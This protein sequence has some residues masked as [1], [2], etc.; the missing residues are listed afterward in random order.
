VLNELLR[1]TLDRALQ[2]AEQLSGTP[3]NE[4]LQLALWL[5]DGTG[6]RLTN[7]VM[8]DRL[9]WE[10]QT[11]EP[12]TIDEYSSWVAVRSFCAG[13]PLAQARDIYASRWRFVR[14]TPLVLEN[15][16]HGRI[17]LGC[18]TTASLSPRHATQLD[19]MPDE[20]LTAFNDTLTDAVVTLLNLPFV[21]SA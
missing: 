12:V 18:L 1:T 20:V 13:T 19:A 7:W 3:W 10:R 4:V 17:P 15:A 5:V 8:T 2:Q 14:G 9:H 21:D 16:V 6:E 11:V